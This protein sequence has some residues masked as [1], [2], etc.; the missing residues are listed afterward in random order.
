MAVEIWT[1]GVAGCSVF[2]RR[3]CRNEGA[4]TGA[5]SGNVG[6]VDDVAFEVGR[7]VWGEVLA[8]EPT[9][10]QMLRGDAID[11]ALAAVAQ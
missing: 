10:R 11:A 8:M 6:P 7:S 1:I 3:R 9:P 2:S 4:R 5:V